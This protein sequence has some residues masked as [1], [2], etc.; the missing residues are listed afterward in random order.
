[1]HLLSIDDLT[2]ESIEKI[3]NCSLVLKSGNNIYP[4][5]SELS[6][7]IIAILFFEPSTRTKLSFESAIYRYNGKVINYNENTS[8]SQKGETFNDTIKT[9]EK[10]CDL[11]IIRHMD[12]NIFDNI[13]LLT[14]KPVINAGNGKIEHPTQALIDVTTIIEHF[15]KW[16]RDMNN[17]KII[18][19]G[20]LSHSR[21]INS[22]IKCLIKV[23]YNIEFYIFNFNQNISND[24]L[25]ILNIL[26]ENKI[27]YFFINNYDNVSDID[28]IYITRAQKERHE[29]NYND[30]YKMTP[31]VINKMKKGSAVMHPFPRNEELS[32]ECD[33][34]EKSIYFNQ[35]ENGI[36]V[37][38]VILHYCLGY[39]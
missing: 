39:L 13:Q 3:I 37:R 2:K 15:K 1:M 29:I 28:I 30:K 18:I 38:N 25:E 17:L 31:T 36:Y 22:L 27:N 24:N 11:L 9:I 26:N 16:N 20:D 23:F 12:D 5:N 4:G 32:S 34:N 7:Y 8:S 6:S 35:I 21:V 19:A 10:Y 33:N 14:K